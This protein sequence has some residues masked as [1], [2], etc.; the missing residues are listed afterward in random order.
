MSLANLFTV[1]KKCEEVN[2]V[3]SWK[4]SHFMVQEGIML[5]HKGSKKGIEVDKTKIDLIYNL[6]IPTSVKQVRSFLGHAGF[7]RR[8]I[9]DF[10]KVA[11]PLTNLL[12]KDT[13]FVF[14]ESCVEAFEKL[15]S[16]LV[17]TPIM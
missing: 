7:Y 10:N 6:S 4:K 13:P 9:K 2:L 12:S 14:N 16:L 15:R 3:L 1:L 11:H 17:S 5:G 8:F